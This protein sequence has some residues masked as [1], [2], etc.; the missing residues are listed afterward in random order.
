MFE[1]LKGGRNRS[2][3]FNIQDTE[4]LAHDLGLLK[5][6]HWTAAK[7]STQPN[8]VPASPDEDEGER[9]IVKNARDSV[10]SHTELVSAEESA[11]RD[12]RA[13]FQIDDGFP[14]RILATSKAES[15]STVTRFREDRE[16]TLAEIRDAEDQTRRTQVLFGVTRQARYAKNRWVVVTLA[17]LVI[18]LET[19]VNGPVIADFGSGGLLAGWSLA[20]MISLGN[21]GLGGLGSWSVLRLWATGHL[22]TWKRY[23]AV[24]IVLATTTSVCWINLSVAKVRDASVDEYTPDISNLFAEGVLP[25]TIDALLLFF[26][27]VIIALTSAIKFGLMSD[28]I[29]ELEAA[30]R[31]M[32]AAV[33]RLQ[34][35]DRAA[36]KVLQ[37]I[38]DYN[39][40]ELQD[41]LDESEEIVVASNQS[42]IESV[43][44]ETEY[45]VAC[46]RILNV[47][48]QVL[49]LR[50]ERLSIA[51]SVVPSFWNNSETSI[52]MELPSVFNLN[53]E[54]ANEGD[55]IKRFN[56][57]KVNVQAAER[58]IEDIHEAARKMVELTPS[59][60]SEGQGKTATNVVHLRFREQVAS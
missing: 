34:F 41:R 27:G 6:I 38:A 39:L 22:A 11:R 8:S 14:S 43:S 4:R 28:P 30:D 51:S 56:A 15:N 50:R 35:M 18:A 29:P 1:L 40:A 42:L 16:K 60:K 55:M 2:K 12:A 21:V 10:L 9:R 53:A 19:A 36:P 45:A 54:T 13:A 52:A 23:A 44:A 48:E 31:R 32:R 3:T 37:Q 20:F 33:H 17:F 26:L 47:H 24:L 58:E 7:W 59:P 46:E 49:R 25:G 57:L 5:A